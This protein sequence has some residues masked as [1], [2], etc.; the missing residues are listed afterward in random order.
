[1]GKRRKRKQRDMEAA[2]GRAMMMGN[3]GGMKATP[4]MFGRLAQAKPN[5]QFLLGAL[6]GAGA[7]Y[8]LGDERLRGKLMK[9]GMNLYAGLMSGFEEMKEQADD[10]RA[11]M[12]AERGKAP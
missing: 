9:A 5:E 12:E 1:M 11:E 8:V 3:G 6:I 7:A 4:G 2:L 10:I